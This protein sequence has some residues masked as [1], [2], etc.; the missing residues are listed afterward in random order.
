M[1]KVHDHSSIN[2]T[3]DFLIRMVF[4]HIV[5][6]LPVML[7]DVSDPSVFVTVQVKVLPNAGGLTMRTFSYV[8]AAL[9]VT[10]CTMV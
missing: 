6:G 1:Y 2:H 4:I 9:L 8:D 3:I 7:F 5:P 10:V